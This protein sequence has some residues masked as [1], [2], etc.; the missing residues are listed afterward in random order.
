MPKVASR[1]H[2]ISVN[3][4]KTNEIPVFKFSSFSNYLSFY[5]AI[6]ESVLILTT[7][8][9]KSKIQS[10]EMKLLMRV[11]ECTTREHKRNETIKAHFSKEY[12]V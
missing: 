10:Q 1:F 8:E 6:I 12:V 11:E 2:N 5:G 3:S 4:V 7:E 9:E